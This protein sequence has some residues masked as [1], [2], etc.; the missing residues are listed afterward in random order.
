MGK[1][2]KLIKTM[3][4]I[5]DEEEEAKEKFKELIMKTTFCAVSMM[6]I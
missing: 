4:L 1:L 5:L 2:I 6:V 3:L